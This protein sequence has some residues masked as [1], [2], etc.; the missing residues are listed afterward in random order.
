[1][2][3]FTFLSIATE[4]FSRKGGVST[5][6]RELCSALRASGHSVYCYVPRADADEVANARSSGVFLIQATPILNAEP[7]AAL[8]RRPPFRDDVRPDVVIGHGRFTGPA[9]QTLINDFYRDALRVHVVHVAPGEIEPFK[10]RIGEQATVRFEQRE[11]IELDLAETANLVIAVGPLLYDEFKTL[12]IGRDAR[13]PIHQVNPGLS[14]KPAPREMPPQIRILVMGR[15]EDTILKGL[16][17]ASCAMKRVRSTTIGGEPILVIRGATPGTGDQLAQELTGLSGLARNRIRVKEYTERIEQ[18]SEDIRASSLVLMPSRSEGFGL[19]GL[20]AISLGVPVLLSHQSGLSRLLLT[21]INDLTKSFVAPVTDNLEI[22]SQ[23]WSSRI[24]LLLSNRLE[25]FEKIRSVQ[26]RLSQSLTWD[27]TISNFLTALSDVADENPQTSIST[28]NHSTRQ[29]PTQALADLNS[30]IARIRQIRSRALSTLM[31]AQTKWGPS[32]FS[33]A[34]KVANVCE[35]LLAVDDDFLGH[36]ADQL[37]EPIEWL[38]SQQRQGGFP[39]LSR[40]TITTHCT[41]LGALACTR[42]SEWPQLS[43]QLRSRAAEASDY[44]ANT[45]LQMAGERGWGTWGKGSIRIQPTIWALRAIVPKDSHRAELM[46]RFEQLRTMHSNGFPGCFGFAPGTP[47]RVSPT[48]SFLLLCAELQNI[49]YEP[50]NKRRFFQETYNAAQFVQNRRPV[51][52]FW[53]PE[54]EVYY[55]DKEYV[56]IVGHIEQLTWH[57][58][59]GPIAVEALSRNPTLIGRSDA[60]SGWI[61]GALQMLAEFDRQSSMFQTHDYA[62]FGLT[63]PVFPTAYACMALTGLEQ[64]V[65]GSD[66]MP[67]HVAP[68]PPFLPGTIIRK[69]GLAVVREGRVLL[70]RKFGTDKLIVPGGG[71]EPNETQLDALNR[72]IKEELGTGIYLLENEPIGQFRAAAAFE[73]GMEVEIILYRGE[74]KSLPKP[75]SEIEEL[76]WYHPSDDPNVLSL[77]IREHIIPSLKEQGIL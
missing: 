19:V 68:P 9:A 27:F 64:W 30:L 55:V 11:R 16:D 54:V 2:R 46:R 77:I 34:R 32:L 57:H 56:P 73:P 38:L 59:A 39:S 3:H 26:K 48:A 49:G 53:P 37:I 75:S 10:N 70:A 71:V 25:T 50:S 12:L 74:L 60:V 63:E 45:C 72:E 8:Y 35:V 1:M 66:Q 69:V 23:E 18:L 13:V 14:P 22:D 65:A 62:E 67:D 41:A 20:E 15:A 31:T 5:F 17:I 29:P 42:V 76:I 33:S 52:K 47:P 24:E 61:D 21:E 7:E 58:V 6:N 43:Q 44:A 51:D 36:Q 4:W 40:D 28:L